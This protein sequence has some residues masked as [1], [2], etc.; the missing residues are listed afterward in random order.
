MVSNL[1]LDTSALAKRYIRE[2]G[3]TWV[4]NLT[5]P[6][7]GNVIVVAWLVQVELFSLFARRHREKAL[8]AADLT[9]LQNEFLT[10]AETPYLVVPIDETN[11]TWA[12]D[13]VSRYQLRALDAIHLACAVKAQAILGE[14]L[15]FI[16]ADVNQL[17]AASGE[18]VATDSPLAH[19]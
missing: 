15:T 7:A 11:L 5:D 12:R 8:S 1:F 6:S 10:H 17:T 18:G 9:T 13:L 4:E 16:S 14:P 19:P 3:S 2:T